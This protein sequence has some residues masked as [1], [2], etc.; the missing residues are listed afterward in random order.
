M[1]FSIRSMRQVFK[2]NTG[3]RVSEDASKELGEFI[4]NWANQISEEAVKVASENDRATVRAE[5]IREVLRSR[6]DRD[7]EYSLDI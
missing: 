3:K 5:D 6:K 2:S 4:D 1:E 7:V